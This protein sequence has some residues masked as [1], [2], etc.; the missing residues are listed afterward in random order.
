MNTANTAMSTPILGKVYRNA[1]RER[2][3]WHVVKDPSGDFFNNK[4]RAIDLNPVYIAEAYWPT[5]IVFQN[6]QTRQYKVWRGTSFET[7]KFVVLDLR[8]IQAGYYR[9]AQH[10]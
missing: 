9:G 1:L 7:V 5:G 2:R 3:P 6:T 8:G 4:F 10:E